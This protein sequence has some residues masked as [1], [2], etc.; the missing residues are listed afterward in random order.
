MDFLVLLH[1]QSFVGMGLSSFS[2]YVRECRTIMGFM[3]FS[4]ILINREHGVEGNKWID[5]FARA[6]KV[7]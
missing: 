2:F 7:V 1:G 6:A 3:P 4:S 5:L